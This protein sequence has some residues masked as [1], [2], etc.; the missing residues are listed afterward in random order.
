LYTDISDQIKEVISTF[1]ETYESAET[2]GKN[3][4]IW[5]QLNSAKRTE[6]C[7]LQGLEEH[8]K[9]S[10]IASI[11]SLLLP[12]ILEMLSKH[13]GLV[14][15]HEVFRAYFADLW[16]NIDREAALQRKRFLVCEELDTVT[17]RKLELQQM[18]SEL[19]LDIAAI[20]GY[21]S[22]EAELLRESKRQR[23]GGTDDNHTET[24]G[25]GCEIS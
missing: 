1:N 22:H 24:F 12:E 5:S 7:R 19:D 14:E 15:F 13:H 25:F 2:I 23:T 17:A 3:K 4:V 10:P 6:M 11:G 18:K 20:S 16:M 9:T 8:I 21:H